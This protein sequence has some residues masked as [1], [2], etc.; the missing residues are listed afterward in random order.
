MLPESVFGWGRNTHVYFLPL[1]HYLG[2]AQTY[3]LFAVFTFLYFLVALF[4]LPETKARTL[5]EI[6]LSF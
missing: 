1:S 3:W 4:L 6:Q 2:M 5:E